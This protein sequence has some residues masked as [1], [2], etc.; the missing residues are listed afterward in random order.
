MTK[1]K[2]Q[3]E[4][5]ST[6]TE[7][8][9]LDAA[10]EIYGSEPDSLKYLH[11]VL[12]QCGLPYRQPTRD[13]RDYIKPNGNVTLI[14]TA[15]HLQDP[16]TSEAVLQGLPYGAKPRLLLI[17]LCTQAKLTNSPKVEI[18]DSMS[19]FMRDLGLSV[20][21]G[22]TG[23][24][25]RFKEQLNRLA[26]A[27]MQLLFQDTTKTSMRNLTGP[28]EHYDVWFPNNPN[29][30]I[31]WPTTVTLSEGF[32]NSLM[33]QNAVPLDSRAIRV[34]QHSAMALDVY[35]WLAH[36]LCRIPDYQPYK[37]SWSALQRQFGPDFGPSD[38]DK[39]KFR[40]NFKKALTDV[41]K[42]YREARVEIVAS[43]IQIRQSASPVPR[44]LL[45]HP[46]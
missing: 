24:I 6:R 26:A 41:R 45:S 20:S 27:R 18:G 22:K 30:R 7:S 21:G 11:V 33:D 13:L 14:L 17:H 9:L 2:A 15:G 37:I 12:A 32:F 36:R 34:L 1:R 16:K 8:R 10:V 3:D 39:Y 28:I 19:A 40:T 46:K 5:S 4:L 43:G 25:G 29:Q 44:G 42:E 31:L 23:S 38:D 35:C